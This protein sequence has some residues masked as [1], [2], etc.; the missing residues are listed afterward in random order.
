VRTLSFCPLINDD[1]KE[2]QC[3]FWQE[4]CLVYDFLL[5][6][7]NIVSAG[8]EGYGIGEVSDTEVTSLSEDFRNTPIQQLAN[9]F[10]EFCIDK[11]QELDYPSSEMFKYFLETKDVRDQWSLKLNDRI[12]LDRVRSMAQNKTS[13]NQLQ[14][15]EELRIKEKERLP[16]IVN[17]CVEWARSHGFTR[18]R[19]SDVEAFLLE[20][21]ISVL[22]ETKRA[23][24]SMVN[25]NLKSKK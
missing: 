14:I 13:R 3:R 20:N 10:I 16:N 8:L 17:D 23:L 25:V 9:E 12:F 21:D 6:F 7:G 1:C 18:V 22:A 5:V 24:Y 11:F 4:S 19:Q 2:A 15:M